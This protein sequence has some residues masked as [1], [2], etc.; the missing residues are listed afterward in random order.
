MAIDTMFTGSPGR[1]SHS[2]R[3]FLS[4]GLRGYRRW[5]VTRR[6]RHALLDMTD[7]QLSDIGITRR[8]A[9]QEIGKSFYW[10]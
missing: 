8:E 10:D 4:S 3:A 9:R 2:L 5:L 7:D 6:T 1:P